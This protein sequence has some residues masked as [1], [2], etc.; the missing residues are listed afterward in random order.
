LVDHGALSWDP[1][2]KAANGTDTGAF[3]LHSDKLVPAVDQLMALVLGIKARGDKP[4]AER[5]VAGYLRGKVVSFATITQRW[6]RVA[7]PS[8]VYAVQL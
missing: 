8:M 6:Q 7:K 2:A 4:A 3:T 5:L 1:K